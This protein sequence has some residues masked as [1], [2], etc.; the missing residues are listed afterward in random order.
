MTR[1]R[2][3]GPP[4]PA[5]RPARETPEYW[6]EH[7]HHDGPAGA[8]PSPA[9]S[10]GPSDA[11]KNPPSGGS[12]GRPAQSPPGLTAASG[13]PWGEYAVLFAGALLGSVIGSTAATVVV[14]W[15]MVM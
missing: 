13:R 7:F 3:K 12:A 8:A 10:G 11:P 9:P 4:P 1:D 6:L 15:L 5:Q 2:L 14:I